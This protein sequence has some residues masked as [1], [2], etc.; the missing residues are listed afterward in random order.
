MVATAVISGIALNAYSAV[1]TSTQATINGKQC[2]THNVEWNI[3]PGE[4]MSAGI[5]GWPCGGMRE[6]GYRG[7]IEVSDE[8]KE[9]VIS[10]AKNDTDVQNLLNEGYNIIGVRPIIRT[11]VEGDGTVFS[12]ATSAVLM[13]EKDTTGRAYIW[14]DL[15]QGK[16]MQ[17]EILA[18]T[19][20]E[21]P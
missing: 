6:R 8:F 12:K 4:N 9:N 20:I 10:I 14:V 13:L 17:I 19:I 5:K 15:E 11:V 2:W 18:M 1:N 3:G 7:F 21:K 16:V